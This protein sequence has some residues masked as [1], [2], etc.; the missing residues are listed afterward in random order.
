MQVQH[1]LAAKARPVSRSGLCSVISSLI[2]S[3]LQRAHPSTQRTAVSITICGI[4][5]FQLMLR[6]KFS[7]SRF[8][9]EKKGV[10]IFK[11]KTKELIMG[12]GLDLPS[13]TNGGDGR[14]VWSPR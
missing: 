12:R 5:F 1:I 8:L 9:T 4:K 14:P 11:F 3:F 10:S 7:A 6:Y 13:R 2:P